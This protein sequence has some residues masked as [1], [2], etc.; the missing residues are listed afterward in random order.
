MSELSKDWLT[1]GLIDYEYKKYIVLAYLKDVRE[2]F[3]NYVLYP[4]LSDLVFHYKNLLSIKE[5]KQLI[6]ENFPK[7]ISKADFEKLQITYKKIVE[8][9]EVMKEIE[10]ILEFS[11]GKFKDILNE[12]KEIYEFVEENVE[13]MPIGL[14]PLYSKEGY[15]MIN[16]KEKHDMEVYRYLITVF[17]NANETYRGVHTEFLETVTKS[18][19]STY[20]TLK[21]DLIRRYRY[22]PNPAT[23]LITAKV[24]LP[25]EETLFPVAKRL[26]VKYINSSHTY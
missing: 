15:L 1:Q 18:V 21:L 10:D 11:I 19:S 8:D 17:E 25:F 13:I 4:F 9:D 3:N 5:N 23:Y 26:L 24:K 20:E 7:V 22:L 12:G 14:S 6:H 2:N 16:Q